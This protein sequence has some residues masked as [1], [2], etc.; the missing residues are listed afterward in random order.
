M[1]F[2]IMKRNDDKNEI[3][4]V[5]DFLYGQIKNEYGMG[6]APKFHYDIEGLKEY[7]GIV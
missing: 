7:C 2:K 6:T 4:L 5:Q 3:C 1:D